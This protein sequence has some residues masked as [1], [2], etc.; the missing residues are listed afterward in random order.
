[1]FRGI[2]RAE[3]HHD[4]A[5]ID[6]AGK[7]ARAGLPAGDSVAVA[8]AG[9]G[10]RVDHED[11]SARRPPTATKRVGPQEFPDPSGQESALVEDGC[12]WV[13]CEVQRPW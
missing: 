8:A 5:L 11:G 1:M 4:V 10:K 7:L 12:E 2:D 3:R 9:G 13:F 6:E